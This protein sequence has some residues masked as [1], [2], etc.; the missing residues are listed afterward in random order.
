MKKI[1]NL[2][3]AVSLFLC[4]LF[5]QPENTILHAATVMAPHIL[6]TGSEADLAK[7]SEYYINTDGRQ[8][9]R[10]DVVQS[11][12]LEI[13]MYAQNSGYISV[14][15]HQQADGS[16]LP[17]YIGFPCTTDRNN[18]YTAYQYLK[19][20]TYYLRFPQNSYRLYLLLYPST[21]RTIKTGSTVAAYC[22]SVIS[23]TFTYKAT[24]TGYV[25]FTQKRLV[26]TAAP[27][28]VSFYD[29]K[30]KK[31]TDVVSDHEIATEI[32]LPVMK[33][34]TYKIKIKTLS[35]DGQQ[36]YQLNVKFTAFTEKNG[37]KKS[38][39]T[40]LKLKNTATGMVYAEDSTK[41]ADWYKV[42]NPKDQKLKLDYEGN[43]TSGSINL[44]IYNQKGKKLG[45]YYLM[46]T[47]GKTATYKLLN[48]NNS[49][50]IPK[51]T[52]YIKIT[53]SRKQ[54]AGV[55]DIKLHP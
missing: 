24:E 11:G 55:Y 25:T 54:T 7:Y 53:K 50:I 20:G 46:P 6:S 49:S 39:A 17:T 51:G 33:G 8:L 19:K 3:L 21:S 45:T 43:V 44:I 2:V 4:T 27:M 41:T 14:E 5:V 15:M 32:V 16:D 1:A 31:I 29:E 26:E 22:D 40:T 12:A 13:S 30:G 9:Y 42:S 36:Y 18:Q 52:Y 23:D 10:L 28:S 48:T 37:S 35:V 34:K 47:K 38:E